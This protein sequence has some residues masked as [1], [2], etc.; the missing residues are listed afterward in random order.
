M[1]YSFR[2]F[3]SRLKSDETQFSKDFYQSVELWG[4]LNVGRKWEVLGFVPYNINKQRSDDDTRTT[5]GLGD[6][7]VI[8]NRKLLDKRTTDNKERMISQQLWVGGGAK[9]P[10][11]KFTPDATDIIPD[12]NNQA[13]T[14]SVDF[15]VNAMYTLHIND[16]GINSNINYKVNGSAQNF[17][18]GNRLNTTAF[19]FHS[20][21]NKSGTSSINPNVGLLYEKLGANKMMNAKVDDTGG[22]AL[23]AATGVEVNFAKIAV[24]VNAQL[25]I[26]QD[27]SNK[28]TETK[29]RGMMHVTFLF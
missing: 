12:A 13:G 5:N 6:I 24:G 22:D 16:W 2:T 28:Q 10:T 25:P 18:F 9:L 19:I 26:S 27:L 14:G 20:F 8:I 29:V 1:R 21:Q 3:E 23:L 15:I 4:G 17:R 11:G 7:S